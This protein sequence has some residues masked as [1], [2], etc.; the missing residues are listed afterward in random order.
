MSGEHPTVDV[1]HEDSV[2]YVTLQRPPVNALSTT[3][4]ELIAEAFGVDPDDP[5]CPRLIV[6]EARGRVFCAGQDRDEFAALPPV[7]AGRYLERA[8]RAVIAAARCPVPIVSVVTGP[9]VGAGALLVAVSDHVIMSEDSWLSFPEA[10]TGVF[11]GRTLLS[12][13]VPPPMA[14]NL[15]MTGE[16][17]GARRL[18]EVG[19]VACVVAAEE[20]AATRDRV[21]GD[22]RSLPDAALRWLR[23]SPERVARARE[24]EEEIRRAT[25]R[26]G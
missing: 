16:R 18:F 5:A 23:G 6:L 13:F 22:L 14:R 12:S 24:Y 25:E 15:L 4:Y 1:R 21:L 26:P 11:V 10:R 20:V 8:G 2:R 7:E 17:V 9:A 19:S 3:E